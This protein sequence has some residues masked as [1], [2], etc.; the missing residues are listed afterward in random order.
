MK[1]LLKFR[2][3]IGGS[4]SESVLISQLENGLVLEFERSDA[5]RKLRLLLSELL[6]VVAQVNRSV[7]YYLYF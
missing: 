2:S 5:A 6:F 3:K 4:S 7:N 1:C